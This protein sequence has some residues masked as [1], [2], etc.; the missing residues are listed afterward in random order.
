MCKPVAAS[1]NLTGSHGEDDLHKKL[2]NLHTICHDMFIQEQ[3]EKCLRELYGLNKKGMDSK[4]KSG[5]GVCVCV[6]DVFI[7]PLFHIRVMR[8]TACGMRL[9]KVLEA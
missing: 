5:G 1:S 9:F 8:Y 3:V 2:P 7:K 4:L 6:C